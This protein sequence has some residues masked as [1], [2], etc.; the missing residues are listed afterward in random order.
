MLQIH[1]WKINNTKKEKP[2]AYEKMTFNFKVYKQEH[3]PQPS[4]TSPNR[5]KISFVLN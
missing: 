3:N 4:N 1:H 2:K 5:M